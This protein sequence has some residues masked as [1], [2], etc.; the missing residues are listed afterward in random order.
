MPTISPEL[1][2]LLKGMDYPAHQSD[3]VR[4]ASREGI[5]RAELMRLAQMTPRS[6][7]GR[8]DVMSELRWNHS[9][10][11]ITASLRPAMA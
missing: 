4:E 9:A 5:A 11:T 3:L 7:S 1:T 2:A 8:F 6:Y 10:H